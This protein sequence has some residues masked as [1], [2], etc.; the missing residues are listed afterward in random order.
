MNEEKCTVEENL[1]IIGNYFLIKINTD[2]I[3]KEAIPGNFVMVGVNTITD[4][5]LKRPFGIFDVDDNYIYIYYE[6]VGKASEILSK[7]RNGDTV[8]I[9]G[10]LGNGF[11]IIKDKKILMIAGG[12]GIAPIYYGIKNYIKTNEVSLIYGAVSKNDL[13]LLDRIE[14][15]DLQNTF[16]YTDD[17]SFGKKGFVSSDLSEIINNLKV[18]ITVSCGPEAMFKSLNDILINT[19]TEDFVSMEAIMGCGIGVCHSCVIETLNDGYKKVCTDGPV[20]NIGE[21]KW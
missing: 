3:A 10:P 14:K 6:V 15:L 16:I 1:N 4:P 11:P 13:N 9:V 5:L 2:L 21:I 17:G 8:H 18:D 19:S 20:F 7:K 12:R